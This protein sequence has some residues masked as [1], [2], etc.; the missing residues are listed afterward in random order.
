M[1]GESQPHSDR[2]DAMDA[3]PQS[4]N[5][6]QEALTAEYTEYA[7]HRLLLGSP[8]AYSVYSEVY[9]FREDSSQPANNSH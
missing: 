2:R 3:E 8:S 7:E 1:S 9:L 5:Q 4:L 6:G